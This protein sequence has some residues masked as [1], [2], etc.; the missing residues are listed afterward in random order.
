MVSLKIWSY[1]LKLLQ[2]DSKFWYDIW[3]HRTE[4]IDAEMN[5]IIHQLASSARVNNFSCVAIVIYI[6]DWWLHKDVQC[7]DIRAQGFIVPAMLATWMHRDSTLIRWAKGES[8]PLGV[9]SLHTTPLCQSSKSP[10]GPVFN[11]CNLVWYLCEQNL[12]WFFS[13]LQSKLNFW[14]GMHTKAHIITLLF[15]IHGVQYNTMQDLW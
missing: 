7:K 12:S 1:S 13:D 8:T 14:C 10:C 11:V 2:G 9:L 6:R 5:Y 4:F 3:S 15:F